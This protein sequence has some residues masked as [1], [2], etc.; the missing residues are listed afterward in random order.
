VTRGLKLAALGLALLAGACSQAMRVAYDNA[1]AFLHWRMQS[2]LQ[3]AGEA[4]EDLDERIDDFLAWHR[5]KALPQYARISADAARRAAAGLSPADLVWGYDS[6]AAQA[7]ESA[8][9]AAA[10]LAPMLDRLTPEQVAHMEKRLADDNRKFARE[11]RG[12]EKD[13][14]NRRAKRTVEQLE[15]WVGKLSKEQV[16]RVR[17][18][19]ESSPLF[20]D[21][22][23]R[24]RKRVQ[25]EF[26]SIVRAREARKR[27]PV[28]VENWE[29]GRDPAYVA[30]NKALRGEFEKLL[31]DFDRS[32][33]A[34]QR[35]RAV[36]RLRSFSEDFAA[37]AAR[38]E[39]ARQ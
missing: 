26:L 36:S 5:A 16:A 11:N 1:D 29:R 35:A 15:D 2:Y 31:L 10:R 25:S 4:S 37:L 22:R 20:D 32:L 18:F 24:E 6:F 8:Q 7:K 12:S 19:S 13:R 30:A 14:R 17:Q 28:L 21:L 39:H 23:D 3:L 9:Q 33:S 34:E 38:A 27:L